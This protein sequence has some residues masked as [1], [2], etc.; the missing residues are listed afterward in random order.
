MKPGS[1]IKWTEEPG[2]PM[3]LGCF[4]CEKDI[5]EFTRFWRGSRPGYL[6]RLCNDCYEK[7][8]QQDPGPSLL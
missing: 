2:Y 8:F 7:V 1:V 6:T 4:R 5:P 3:V